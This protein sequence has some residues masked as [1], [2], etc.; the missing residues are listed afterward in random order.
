M[1]AMGLDKMGVPFSGVWVIS[2]S[3]A[4]D[5]GGAILDVAKLH[6]LTPNPYLL[7]YANLLG[8]VGLVYGV[9]YGTWRMMLDQAQRQRASQS[10]T[11]DDNTVAAGV[12][13]T[14]DGVVYQ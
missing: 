13:L 2:E 5:L 11:P 9:R 1:L 10:T 8:T 14:P 12:V 7:A 3:E 6:D 4:M